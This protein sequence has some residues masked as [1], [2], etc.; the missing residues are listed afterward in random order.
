MVRSSEP[1]SVLEV[2]LTETA[3]RL[4]AGPISYQRG[5]RY[6]TTQ[7]VKKLKETGSELSATVT[8]TSQYRVRIWVEGG[9]LNFSCTC[10][11]GETEEF[12]KHCVAAGLVWL[13]AARASEAS[14]RWSEHDQPD[15]DLRAYLLT[16][17]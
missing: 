15:V 4:K 13:G 11:V 5:E 10:P 8:G 6:A 12:C 1:S 3:L 14:T 7:R 17:S 2:L 16:R 9:D